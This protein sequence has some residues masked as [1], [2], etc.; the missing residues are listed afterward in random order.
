[1]VGNPIYLDTFGADK[2]ITT[3]KITVSSVVV[4]PASG[5]GVIAAFTDNNG[6]VVLRL[7]S[8]AQNVTVQWNPAEPFTF[9]GLNY[10]HT[11]GT[12]TT[13]DKVYIF[14]V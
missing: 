9:D 13:N 10:K 11:P 12:L 2:A 3:N 14:R 4:E 1:M 8:T 5:A 6:T 7:R